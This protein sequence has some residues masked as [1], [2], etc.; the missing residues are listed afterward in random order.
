MLASVHSHLRLSFKTLY[1]YTYRC[2]LGE[3]YV[4]VCKNMHISRGSNSSIK[5]DVAFAHT[6]H[7]EASH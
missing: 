3:R 4:H 2:V 6:S 1:V 7:R 5:W